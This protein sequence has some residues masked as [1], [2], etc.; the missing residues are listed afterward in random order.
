MNYAAL[1][2]LS[3]TVALSGALAPGPLLA[4]VIYESSRRGFKSGPLM[5]AGHAL[6]EAGMVFLIIFGAVGF[7]RNPLILKILAAAGSLILLLFGIRMLRAAKTNPC[8]PSAAP[9]AAR[10]NLIVSGMSISIANP[11]WSLW[12]LTAGLGI[13]TASQ[14]QGLQAIGVFF[15]GHILADLG[16]YS[17]VALAVSK[18]RKFMP[19]GFLKGLNITLALLL[20]G[21]SFG[22][23]WTL[24][25]I[26]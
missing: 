10:Q 11:Y 22:L 21:F 6:A 4:G 7:I 12:W 24:F 3:F 25:R 14:C 13:I 1:F 8:A 19:A 16:W 26:R 17:M 20:I 23:F 15:A 9:G 5:V 2:T 18:G